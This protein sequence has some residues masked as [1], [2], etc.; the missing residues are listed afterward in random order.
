M[1]K[2]MMIGIPKGLVARALTVEKL[3]V[4]LEKNEELKVIANT[5]AFQF[6]N[7]Y[8]PS[9]ENALDLIHAHV[10]RIEP[11]DL[12]FGVTYIRVIKETAEK[13]LEAA[14]CK[15]NRPERACSNCHLIDCCNQ[16]RKRR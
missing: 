7:G 1:T 4:F 15:C 14:C 5:L 13:I 2:V 11:D 6:D 9:L 10:P 3:F 8:D 12:P 16:R